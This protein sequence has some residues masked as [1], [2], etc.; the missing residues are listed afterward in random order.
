MKVQ[1]NIINQVIPSYAGI[2]RWNG[3]LVVYNESELHSMRAIGSHTFGNIE[4]EVSMFDTLNKSQATI[5]YDRNETAESL[6]ELLKDQGVSKVEQRH[7]FQ[8]NVEKPMPIFILTF[9]KLTI[10]EIVYIGYEICDTRPYYPLPLRCTKCQKYKHTRK[11]CNSKSDVCRLC[12]EEL[13]HDTCGPLKCINCHGPHASNDRACPVKSDEI[14]IKK[15][16][17][18]R[19][20]SYPVARAMFFKEQ[21]SGQPNR[22]LTLYSDIARDDVDAKI[23]ALNDKIE[24]LMAVVKEKDRIIEALM[25]EKE[26]KQ[27]FEVLYD[28]KSLNETATMIQSLELSPEER[29][30]LFMNQNEQLKTSLTQG[31]ATIDDFMKCSPNLIALTPGNAGLLPADARERVKKK[32][33][34]IRNDNGGKEP[35]FYVDLT[36]GHIKVVL[37]PP[38]PNG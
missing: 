22:P 24:S 34:K 6:L 17:V 37:D 4:F 15:I 13:P 21:K 27:S 16:Q 32:R 2:R 7:K 14:A 23:K 25:M 8:D 9:D 1:E 12:A 10:P 28:L 29:F 30:S 35:L 20:V 33:G 5:Y 31:K 38:K 19:R 11:Y 36:D 26:S 3:N 18:D